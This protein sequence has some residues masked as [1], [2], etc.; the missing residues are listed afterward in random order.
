MYMYI[1]FLSLSLTLLEKPR[2]TVGVTAIKYQSSLDLICLIPKLDRRR[3][4]ML[5]L[6]CAACLPSVAAILSYA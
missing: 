5:F 4:L 1:S 2:F 6:L 3:L